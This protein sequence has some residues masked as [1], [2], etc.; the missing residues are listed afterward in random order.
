MI[1]TNEL[2]LRLFY[3][4]T[5]TVYKYNT[6]TFQIPPKQKYNNTSKYTLSTKNKKY[7][8]YANG[9]ISYYSTV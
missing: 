3:V 4:F 6:R 1:I 5:I 8:H 9:I 2:R 7:G